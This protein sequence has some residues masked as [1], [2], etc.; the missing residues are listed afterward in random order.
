MNLVKFG[1][2]GSKHLSVRNVADHSKPVKLKGDRPV[3]RP[4]AGFRYLLKIEGETFR[5]Y[6]VFEVSA[7]Y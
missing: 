5:H 7:S 6:G 3:G 4:Y 1:S 2:H